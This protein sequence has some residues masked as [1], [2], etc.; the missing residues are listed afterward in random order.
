MLPL[1]IPVLIFGVSASNAA[2]VGPLPFGAPFTILCAL[3]LVSFITIFAS[4]AKSSINT[5]IGSGF[6]GDYIIQPAN[7][8]SLNG[9]PTTLAAELAKGA[10]VLEASKTAH[11]F[12]K[13]GLR[14][15]FALNQH[16]GPIYHKAMAKN[17]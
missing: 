9:A 14:N 6:K 12:V 5:A 1:S 17:A 2:I 15:S 8:F 4:S 13:A 10:S 11:D 16:V 7:R 3:T